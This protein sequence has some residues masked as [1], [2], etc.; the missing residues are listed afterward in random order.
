MFM[1][2]VAPSMAARLVEGRE[3][4]VFQHLDFFGVH[5]L[6]VDLDA[7]DFMGAVDRDFHDSAAC[8]SGELSCLHFGLLLFHLFLHLLD[9][10]HHVGLVAA[11][12]ASRYVCF[13][14]SDSF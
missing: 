11:H 8:G 9:L 7:L 1:P 12:A 4:Q 5:D 14:I 6:G 3:E 10:L 13:H 2:P